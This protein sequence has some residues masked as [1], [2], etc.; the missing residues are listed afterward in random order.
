MFKN[1]LLVS[2]LF[3]FLYSDELYYNVSEFNKKY[4]QENVSKEF[5]QIVKAPAVK[6]ANK[7]SKK[8]KIAMVN[9]TL[10]L[11]EYWHRSE[12]ALKKRLKELGIDFEL[13]RYVSK[14]VVQVNK[15]A[16]QL[17]NAIEDDTDYLIFTLDVNKH[18]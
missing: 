18:T 13:K 15:Q 2:F 4:N 6:V 12:V 1:F 9:P 10:Q 16:K 8:I 11:S 14:P 7:K 3:T 17:L 5:T